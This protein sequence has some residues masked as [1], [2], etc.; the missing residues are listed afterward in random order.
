[1]SSASQ[2]SSE[3]I[4]KKET[5]EHL[6]NYERLPIVKLDRNLLPLIPQPTDSSYDPLNYPNWL[7][8]VILLQVA[9]IAFVSTFN[10]AVINPA[11]VP[12]SAEFGIRPVIGTYQTAAAIGSG[13]FG[14]LIFTPFANVYGRR[15]C[16]LIAVFIGFITAIAS[17]LSHSYAGLIVVRMINGFGPSASYGLGAGT[18]VDLFYMHQRGRAMGLFTLT[19]TSGAHLAPIVGGY[20]ARSLGWR[21]CFWVGAILNGSLFLISLFALPE[22]IFDRPENSPP[23]SNHATG[24]LEEIYSPPTFQWRVFV[25]R[26]WFWD[27]HRPKSRRMRR[28]DFF[29][30]PLGML[31]YPSVLFPVILLGVTYGFASNEPALILATLFTQLYNFDTVQNGL[32]N[33]ITLLLG[34][35]LGELCS[36]PVTDW[37]IQ[38]ARKKAV[39]KGDVPPAELR[40]QGIWTGAITVPAGLLM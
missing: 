6:E 28:S 34:A 7:K 19:Q 30:R 10:V 31:K 35:A 23:Y 2:R 16:Y 17:A 20:V 8:Y 22:T 18:I 5:A 37:M 14:P 4:E 33:G 29:I 32:A 24:T 25:D 15:S 1:M 40:L 12:M 9:L 21:W 11:V 27:R 38:R 3:G 26:L 13:A 36:G 39:N